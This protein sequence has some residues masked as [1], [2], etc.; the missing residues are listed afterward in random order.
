MGTMRYFDI[1]AHAR[2]TD[3]NWWHTSHIFPTV[4]WQGCA[5]SVLWAMTYRDIKHGHC[6]ELIS[7]THPSS[8]RVETSHLLTKL[9]LLSLLPWIRPFQ[10]VEW[11]HTLL[12]FFNNKWNPTY[13][14]LH[15]AQHEAAAPMH[16]RQN[17]LLWKGCIE[18]LHKG[19]ICIVKNN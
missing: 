12:S 14:T 4:L 7:G 3:S 2:K 11:G 13:F 10:T 8:P 18:V 16:K 19:R 9:L 5:A 6:A 17:P 15:S 1:C